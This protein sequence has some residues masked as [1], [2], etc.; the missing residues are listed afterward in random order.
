V[1]FIVEEEAVINCSSHSINLSPSV[2]TLSPSVVNHPRAMIQDRLFGNDKLVP[3]MIKDRLFRND[4][5][6]PAIRR[7]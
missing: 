4:K 3:A 1:K 6:V 5:L 7:R 2:I